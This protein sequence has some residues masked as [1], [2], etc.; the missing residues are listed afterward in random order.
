MLFVVLSVSLLLCCCCLVDV[1]IMLQLVMLLLSLVL[2]GGSS[3]PRR[4]LSEKAR[5]EGAI[6]I[7]NNEQLIRVVA[8]RGFPYWF[9]RSFE[10]WGDLPLLLPS[11]SKQGW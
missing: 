4:K 8:Q 10:L 7:N 1:V 5:G 9:L 6:M 11:G 2:L 3:N